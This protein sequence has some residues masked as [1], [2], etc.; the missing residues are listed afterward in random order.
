MLSKSL[1]IKYNK[2]LIDKKAHKK[3]KQ[4][5]DT[6]TILSTETQNLTTDRNT[7]RSFLSN[8]LRPDSTWDVLGAIIINN[9]FHEYY[10]QGDCSILVIPA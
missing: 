1:K 5:I 9:S 2:K 10:S 8:R 3:K 4:M 7:Q 6:K